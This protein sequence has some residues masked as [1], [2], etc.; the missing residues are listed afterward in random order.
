V[1]DIDIAV[2][3]ARKA[4]NTTWGKNVTGFE[5]S[6]LL[7]K[8]ADLMERDQ[9]VLAEVESLNNGKPM[10]IARYE[11]VSSLFL[12]NGCRSSFIRDF[13]IGDSIQCLRYYAGWADKITGQVYRASLQNIFDYSCFLFFRLSKSTTKPSLLSLGMILLEFADKCT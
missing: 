7:N 6:K 13:D 12:F 8:L 5:R 10:K 3:S 11:N 9:E 1:E 4:F 2:A